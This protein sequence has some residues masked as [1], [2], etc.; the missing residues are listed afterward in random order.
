MC[1]LEWET[2]GEEHWL[3][4]SRCGQCDARDERIVTNEQATRYDLE[5]ARHTD[6]I[7]RALH[8]MELESM[9]GE[10]DAFV[11]ALDHDLIDAA[12]FAP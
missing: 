5:L 7:A 8:R 6:Q 11:S 12:D 1:P 9:R 3:I 2:V 10:V 4:T